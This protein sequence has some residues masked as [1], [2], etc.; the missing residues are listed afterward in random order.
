MLLAISLAGFVLW[1]SV[2]IGILA[3]AFAALILYSHFR[4]GNIIPAL[5]ALRNGNIP[6]AEEALASIKRPDFL[7]KRYQAYYYF[8]SGLIDFYYKRIA[9]GCANLE[10]AVDLGLKNKTELSITHL[11]I[12]QGAYMQ[13]DYEKSR[14]HMELCMAQNP[15]DLHVKQRLEELE[16]LLNKQ[17][18]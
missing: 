17:N 2:K 5:M 13:K 16:Q 3:L 7:S 9:E 10:K 12:A 6:G 14:K 15:S 18:N 4:Q 1:S 8:V 11:N